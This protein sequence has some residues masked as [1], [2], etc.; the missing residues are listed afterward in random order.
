MTS[1]RCFSNLLYIIIII[2]MTCSSKW[3]N[4]CF[5]F[6]YT[7]QQGAACRVLGLPVGQTTAHMKFVNVSTGSLGLK[8]LESVNRRV[9][10]PRV[11][12]P[13]A[14]L[15]ITHLILIPIAPCTRNLRHQ[16]SCVRLKRCQI[17]R[18]TKT[19]QFTFF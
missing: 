10:S 13:T 16:S 1:L 9:F 11:E 18:W 17:R 8:L 2:I 19:P 15:H 5:R 6:T 4:S 7:T 14:Q 12:D 3:F